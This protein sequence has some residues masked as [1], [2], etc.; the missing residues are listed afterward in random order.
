MK[1]GQL[2]EYYMRQTFVE[3]LYTKCDEKTITRPL[4]ISLDQ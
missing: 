2:L 1:F 4:S 3:R